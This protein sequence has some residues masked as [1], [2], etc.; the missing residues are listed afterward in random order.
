MFCVL[1]N[2]MF[3]AVLLFAAVLFAA[4]LLSYF[5]HKNTIKSIH[6][7][8]N[9][10]NPLYFF[11]GVLRGEVFRLHAVLGTRAVSRNK[12]SPKSRLCSMFQIII[13]CWNDC[14]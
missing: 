5:H 7:H 1:L 10:I 3:A 4:V 12:P 11:N 6:T 13:I 2:T 14:R 9:T 8:N